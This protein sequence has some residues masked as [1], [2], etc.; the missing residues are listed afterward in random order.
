MS[1][2]IEDMKTLVRLR[3]RDR[4]RCEGALTEAASGHEDCCADLRSKERTLRTVQDRCAAAMHARSQAPGD[5]LVADYC[6]CERDE[7]AALARAVDEARTAV[8]AALEKLGLA[9]RMRQRAQARLDM[10]EARL[11]EERARERRR[12]ARRRDEALVDLRGQTA[13]PA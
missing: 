6:I 8:H 7:L 4:D 2:D 9:R 1:R 11:A 10:L 5:V 12:W 13:I 3:R